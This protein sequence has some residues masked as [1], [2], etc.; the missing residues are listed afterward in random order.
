[1]GIRLEG[2]GVQVSALDDKLP[3]GRELDGKATSSE[4]KDPFLG[5]GSDTTRLVG[6]NGR[7][8]LKESSP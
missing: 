6:P 1:M 7:P 4:A 8:V 3:S 5:S 2:Y